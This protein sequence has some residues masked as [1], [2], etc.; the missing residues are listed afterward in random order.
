MR[1][2]RRKPSKAVHE[3]EPMEDQPDDE[4]QRQ[5]MSQRTKGNVALQV[6]LDPADDIGIS[7]PQGEAHV[8]SAARP[9]DKVGRLCRAEERDAVL[10]V[11]AAV[12]PIPSRTALIDW[13]RRWRGGRIACRGRSSGSKGTSTFPMSAA[14]V[15]AILADQHAA[16]A[17]HGLG[18]GSRWTKARQSGLIIAPKYPCPGP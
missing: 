7:L 14:G 1:R 8:P 11:E 2:S 16:I 12:A 3:F 9:R 17:G 18:A 5:C 15:R 6:T 4:P 10:V 13:R